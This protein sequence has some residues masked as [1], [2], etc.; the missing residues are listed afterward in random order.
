[1]KLKATS[2]VLP[3]T[4]GS[5]GLALRGGRG[6]GPAVT[7]DSHGVGVEGVHSRCTVGQLDR[8]LSGLVVGTDSMMG[9]NVGGFQNGLLSPQVE[10]REP[11]R[12]YHLVSCSRYYY[13][14]QKLIH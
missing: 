5:D 13:H 14:Y 1:M 10:N 9:F 4:P 11:I 3:A 12:T 6:A 8:H 7:A 2:G